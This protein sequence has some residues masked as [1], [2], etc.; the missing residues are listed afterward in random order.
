LNDGWSV[1]GILGAGLRS[2]YWLRW[3]M[4]AGMSVNPEEYRLHDLP[5]LVDLHCHLIPGVDDG[6]HDEDE[7]LRM[8]R[9]AVEDGVG[10]IAATPHAHRCPA[11]RVAG[12]VE[13][14]NEIASEHGLN[15]RIVPGIEVRYDP[16]LF[17]RFEAG[18]FLTWN[19]TRYML[20]EL[21]LSGSW[22]TSLMRTIGELHEAGIWPVLA[23]AERYEDVQRDPTILLEVIAAGVPVQINADSLSG[24]PER[25]ARP[26]AEFLISNQMAHLIASDAH[27]SRWRP[28]RLRP[29]LERVAEL[30]GE[31]YAHTMIANAAA[32]VAGEPLML[33]Q[34]Q[35][36]YRL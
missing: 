12:K 13:R 27:N 33:P 32:I 17:Q 5:P 31:A 28:P 11:N 14:L 19:D 35:V 7:S 8:M 4:G 30:A 10:T 16:N 6:A 25:G 2:V 36:V 22:P 34:P 18:E 23:H 29:A 1:M 24:K 26:A 21:Y 3:R 20:L 9:V 15:L